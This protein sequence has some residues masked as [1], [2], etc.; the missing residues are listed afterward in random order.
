[1]WINFFGL[2]LTAIVGRPFDGI[3]LVP[4]YCPI[5][6][7]QNVPFPRDVWIDRNTK[8]IFFSL[9]IKQLPFLYTYTVPIS[10]K[11]FQQA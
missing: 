4:E 8:L 10:C 3:C 9:L 2:I 11:M 1:M 6:V 7:P 5:I